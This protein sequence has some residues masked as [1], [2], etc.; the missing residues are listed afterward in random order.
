MKYVG[1]LLIFVL[2]I[3]SCM[4]VKGK[5]AYY[6]KHLQKLAVRY[7]EKVTFT[8]DVDPDSLKVANGDWAKKSKK[9]IKQMLDETEREMVLMTDT[10]IVVKTSVNNNQNGVIA[11]QSID[12]KN[13]YIKNKNKISYIKKHHIIDSTIHIIEK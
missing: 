9:Q 13:I 6:R 10:F 3:S 5:I 1:L 8:Q 4:S 12:I 2:G 11:T 7:H